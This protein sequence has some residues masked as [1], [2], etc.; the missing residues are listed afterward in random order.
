MSKR[1]RLWV[2]FLGDPQAIAIFVSTVMLVFGVASPGAS[3][4][5][6]LAD[7]GQAGEPPDAPL[8]EITAKDLAAHLKSAWAG[9]DRGLLEIEFENTI[10]TNWRFM[11]NQGKPDE[12]KPT[13][14][15]FPGRVRFHA[16]GR[17]WRVEYDSMMPTSSNTKLRP[18]RW[19][20]GFDGTQLFDWDIMRNEAKLGEARGYA[21]MWR[22]RNQFWHRGEEFVQALET[23]STG[24]EG[25][26]KISQRTVDGFRCYVV[27]RAYPKFSNKTEEIVSPR[28]VT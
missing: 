23:L 14:V 2:E 9:F 13:I 28:R 25:T 11:M 21:S 12:Q 1:T 15:K 22:P 16:D 7:A 4:A 27:E 17:L 20:S 3:S 26:L 19:T 6:H 5:I 24:S 10:N 8:P 18:D